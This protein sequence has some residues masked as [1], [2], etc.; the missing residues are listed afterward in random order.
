MIARHSVLKVTGGFDEG[1]FLYG[2]DQDLCLSVRKA[3]WKIGFITDAVILHW[4]G[5]SEQDT[6]PIEVWKKKFN[7]ELLFYRK[8]YSKKTI[9]AIRRANIIQ[10]LW[11]VFTLNVT[12]PFYNN[13]EASLKKLEKYRLILTMFREGK[14]VQKGNT[15][16]A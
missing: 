9:K 12:L 13:K 3:G 16:K 4:G 15:G 6:L 2:E 10:A 5:V 1:F 7:A 14:V 11:R 8:H